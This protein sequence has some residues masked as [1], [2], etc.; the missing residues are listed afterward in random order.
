MD[1]D[2]A[3][4]DR[5]YAHLGLDVEVLRR[6]ER[7]RLIRAILILT[8]VTALTLALYDLLGNTGVLIGFVGIGGAVVVAGLAAWLWQRPL[9]GLYVLFGAAVVVDVDYTD[10]TVNGY[11]IAH[12]LPFWQNF[13][14]WTHIHIITSPAELFMGLFL[15]IWLIKG[16]A[17]RNLHFDR[18]SLMRPLGLYMAMILIAEFHGITTGGSLTTSLWEV[19]GQVY[20]FVAYVLVCNLVKTRRA[21]N[22]IVWILI[23]G[24]GFRAVEGT[25]RY[26]LYYRG[27]TLQVVDVFPH[28]QAFFFN[29]FLTMTAILLLYGGPARMKRVALWLLP[30][31]LFIDLAVQR[32]AAVLALGIGLVLLLAITYVA[33][34]ARRRLVGR[35]LLLLAIGLPPYYL[36]FQHSSSS[37]AEPARAIASNFQPDPRDA[38]S[39]Q[40]RIS[41]A[42]DI[43]AT[44]KTSTTNSIIGYG[45]GK[46]MITP[47]ALPDISKIYVWWNIMPHNSILWVWMRL[48]TLGFLLLW[49]LIGTA[50]VQGTTLV[51]R[52]RKDMPLQ[53]LALFIVLMVAQEIAFGY[54]DLQWTNYRNLITVG[55]LFALISRLSRIATQEGLLSPTDAHP[56]TP[57]AIKPGLPNVRSLGVVN[58]RLQHVDA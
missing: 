13:T 47:Y 45:F 20:M 41:E 52:L 29:A 25:I 50:L 2:R 17:H 3:S 43:M 18:G 23:V 40:Y 53:G 5:I 12:Y 51:R 46:P 9:R 42:A 28:E 55:V 8:A 4:H 26:L 11:Y 48:G 10:T 27:H 33:Q 37:F 14:A 32:R 15:L 22:T 34:P 24:A 19:R 7:R 54:L 38:A 39:N 49:F 1:M 30:F 56:H 6:R 58:G 44:M 36:K 35:I 21:I 57:T 31:V 16:I